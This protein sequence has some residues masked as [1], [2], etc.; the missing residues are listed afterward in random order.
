MMD[1]S[2]K[3]STERRTT[4]RSNGARDAFAF[5]F[6]FRDYQPPTR[7]VSPGLLVSSTCLNSCALRCLSVDARVV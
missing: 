4:A 7:T 2:Y 1:L 5:A 3:T 6:A